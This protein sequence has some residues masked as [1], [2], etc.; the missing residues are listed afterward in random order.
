MAGH[1]KPDS[2]APTP[3]RGS[4]SNRLDAPK[5]ISLV[6]VDGVYDGTAL[7]DISS[8]VTIGRGTGNTIELP[9]D[10]QVSSDHCSIRF[11]AETGG[12]V[13]EDRG[14]TNGTWCEGRRVDAAAELKPG[15]EFVVGTT[16]FRCLKPGTTSTFLPKVSRLEDEI[17]RLKLALDPDSTRGLGAATMLALREYS[18]ALTDRHLLLGLTSANPGMPIISHGKG[19][20]SD[21]FLT[22]RVLPNAYWT[23]S[24][25]WIAQLLLVD[26]K[27]PQLFSDALLASPRTQGVLFVAAEEAQ[28]Q[29]SDLVAPYHLLFALFVDDNCRLREW[30]QAERGDSKRLLSEL[31]R[32][33]TNVPREKTSL[34][35]IGSDPRI[36]P[37]PRVASRKRV[38]LDPAVMEVAERTIQT[39]AKYRLASADVRFQALR[40]IVTKVIAEVSPERRTQILEQLRECFPVLHSGPINSSESI[41]LKKRINELERAL[42]D[43]NSDHDR[44]SPSTSIPWSEVFSPESDVRLDLLAAEDATA[45]NLINHLLS[46]CLAIERF[47]IGIVAGLMQRQSMSGQMSLPGFKTTIRRALNLGAAGQPAPDELSGYLAAMET[48]L[49][50]AIAAYHSAPEEW[51]TEFWQKAGPARIEAQVPARFLSDAKCWSQ[52]KNV[53]RRIS[54]DLVGDEIQARIRESA[55]RR[56]DELIAKRSRS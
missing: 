16:V 32:E 29:G 51:F 19:L 15:S 18:D 8:T 43:A 27:Q 2:A 33:R 35:R 25:Q 17:H 6:V 47:I 38:V 7:A 37:K 13:I 55:Q 30:Y 28:R 21:E 14:S 54:P 11:S 36:T 53:V 10:R 46:F 26:D 41:Q 44:S 40:D 1:G 23:G 22:R 56:F 39:A 48:W 52:Y 4:E 42:K 45:V 34:H 50:A 3:R 20:L 24:K 31:A 5:K 9:L 49:V 12:W